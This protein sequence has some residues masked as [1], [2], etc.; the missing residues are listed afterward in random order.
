MIPN[1]EVEFWSQLERYPELLPLKTLSFS[2]GSFLMRQGESSKHIFIIKQGRVRLYRDQGGSIIHLDDLGSGEILGELSFFDSLPRTAHAVALEPTECLVLQP[3]VLSKVT[4]RLPVWIP[5]LARS[6]AHRLRHVLANLEQEP[7]TYL[8]ESLVSLLLYKIPD[9]KTE[10]VPKDLIEEF[11][12]ILRVPPEDIEKKLVELAS[13]GYLICAP[14][15]L[16]IVHMNKLEHLLAEL[17][18]KQPVQGEETCP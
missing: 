10:F 15:S 8:K 4:A 1:K 13:E 14:Q 17:Q 2:T 7:E 9:E 11:T 12:A 3:E 16:K 6:L 5:A 18:R